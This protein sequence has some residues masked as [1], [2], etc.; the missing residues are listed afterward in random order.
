MPWF[1]WPRRP[2]LVEELVDSGAP[3]TSYDARQP[4]P[5]FYGKTEN[6][7]QER[8]RKGDWASVCEEFKLVRGDEKY[9]FTQIEYLQKLASSRFGLCL[10]GYGYK[11]HREIECM[12]MGCVPIVSEGVD[13]DSYANPPVEGVHYLRVKKPEDIPAM[14][15]I[16]KSKWETMSSAVKTWW[17]DNASCKGSFELTKRLCSAV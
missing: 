16:T 3:E 1:F 14:L 5:V 9:P 2:S 15:T 8:R 12:A 10:P 4:G 13:M 11:C 6:L 17:K 7:I